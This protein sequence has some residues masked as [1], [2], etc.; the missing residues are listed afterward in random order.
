MCSARIC[1]ALFSLLQQGLERRLERRRQ[2]QRSPSGRQRCRKGEEGS[3]YYERARVATMLFLMVVLAAAHA[4][5][6]PPN[7]PVAVCVTG[8][9]RAF[10][11]V[12]RV[13]RNIWSHMV[14]PIINEADVF[15]VLDDAT[16]G[17]AGVRA[18]QLSDTHIKEE[19]RTLWRPVYDVALRSRGIE[20]SL[21]MCHGA[22]VARE[23]FLRRNYTWV[24][25]LRPDATYKR[26]YL[27]TMSGPWQQT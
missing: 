3:P 9:A 7:K 26:I 11:A 19:A 22:I 21:S 4:A 23:R 5:K 16:A 18:G 25:R 14:W 2:P 20:E 10:H 1:S 13:H 24:L 17:R 6:T 15:F 12:D 8:L 27:R